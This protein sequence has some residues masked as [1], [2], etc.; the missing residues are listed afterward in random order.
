LG[1]QRSAILDR[2]SAHEGSFQELAGDREIEREERAQ[3]ER[4]AAVL[5][6]LEER[7]HE[8][9]REIESALERL[10]AGDFACDNCGRPIEE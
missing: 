3:E 4:I 10:A 9:L 2:R 1:K 6:S 7:D 5:D 8:R